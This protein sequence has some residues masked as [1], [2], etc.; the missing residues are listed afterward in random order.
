MSWLLI[1]L[2]TYVFIR[3]WRCKSLATR[4]AKINS[5]TK[6]EFLI[7]IPLFSHLDVQVEGDSEIVHA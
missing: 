7:S 2:L 1:D 6:K 5:M 3:E 4:R